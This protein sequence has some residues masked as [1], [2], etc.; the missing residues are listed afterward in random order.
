MRV[1]HVVND[2]CV[3]RKALAL[4]ED[5]QRLAREQ[6]SD[7]PF[8]PLDSD[9]PGLDDLVGIRGPQSEQ[10]GHGAQAGQALHRLMCWAVLACFRG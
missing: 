10:G 7:R 4:G 6:Q 8:L 2:V 1:I 9:F 3:A 5:G